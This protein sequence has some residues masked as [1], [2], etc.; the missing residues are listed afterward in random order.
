MTG[1]TALQ[2]A[3]GELVSNQDRLPV[4]G[5]LLYD[6]S[7][8]I[9]DNAPPLVNALRGA[10]EELELRLTAHPENR[11][12]RAV[13]HTDIF[14]I[15]GG[16]FLEPEQIRAHPLGRFYTA[17][18]SSTCLDLVYAT[19]AKS[20]LKRF[21]AQPNG[22]FHLTAVITDGRNTAKDLSAKAKRRVRR[23]VEA[24]EERCGGILSTRVMIAYVGIGLTEGI[25]LQTCVDRYGIPR[26]W[27]RWYP[28][29]EDEVG[30]MGSELS[31][32]F[33]DF[34]SGGET[35]FRGR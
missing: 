8:S 35:S 33:D 2:K 12:S 19:E 16:A 21:L 31:E 10:G 18:G 4:S 23:V 22:L 7:A 3:A 26:E 13:F 11:I 29:G 5:R 24:A 14:E 25:H 32:S 9:R 27:F 34:T 20:L 28:A 6:G 1:P 17:N 15:L 30:R